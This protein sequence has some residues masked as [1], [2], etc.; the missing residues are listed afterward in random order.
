MSSAAVG[1]S[2]SRTSGRVSSA[3]A[4]HIRWASPPDSVAASRSRRPAESPTCSRTCLPRS[5]ETSGSA[6]RK[7]S[8]TDPSK[9]GARW[10]I[11]PTCLRNVGGGIADSASSRHVIAPPTGS[12]RRFRRRSSVDF[13]DPEGPTITVIPCSGRS[14]VMSVRIGA[15]AGPAATS[16]SENP[17]LLATSSTVLPFGDPA[18]AHMRTQHWTQ[19]CAGRSARRY[20]VWRSALPKSA[21]ALA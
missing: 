10:K 17:V 4:T 18:R 16:R 7:L 2:A 11:V 6:T 5:P 15:S 12:S 20:W 21:S 8:S 1:S 14:T 13:P 3:R 19:H 9:S